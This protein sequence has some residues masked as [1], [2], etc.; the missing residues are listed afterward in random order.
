[1]SLHR[2]LGFRAAVAD[3]ARLDAF[4]AELGLSGNATAGYAGSDGELLRVIAE[5]DSDRPSMSAPMAPMAA[6]VA[7]FASVNV[8]RSRSPQGK[9]QR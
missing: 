5:L 7:Y 9:A 6:K 1:M 3:P 8:E 4:Y 2:L